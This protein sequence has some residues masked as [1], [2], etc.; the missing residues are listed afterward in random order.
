M[1]CKEIYTISL[2]AYH[3]IFCEISGVNIF[4]D[5]AI[6]IVRYQFLKSV[7]KVR[8]P[9]KSEECNIIVLRGAL[10][11]VRHVFMHLFDEL[12]GV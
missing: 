3:I 4:C 7:R 1:D 6:N 8:H 11:P 10:K 12:S 2:P 5:A 9:F